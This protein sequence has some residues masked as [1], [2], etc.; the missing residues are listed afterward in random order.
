MLHAIGGKAAI[1]SAFQ[2]QAA[3]VYGDT[4]NISLFTFPIKKVVAESMK[5]NQATHFL[6]KMDTKAP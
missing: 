3:S 1:I 2:S 4:L 6:M 5:R